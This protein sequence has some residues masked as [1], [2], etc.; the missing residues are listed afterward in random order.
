MNFLN[1]HPFIKSLVQLWA[2][3]TVGFNSVLL[4]MLALGITLSLIAAAFYAATSSGIAAT[5]DY[6]YGE[7]DSN[8]TFLSIKVTGTIVGDDDDTAGIAANEQYTSGYDVK[9][10]LYDAAKDD[11]ING[12][13]LEINSPGGTIYGAHAIADGVAHYKKE[14]H[15]PVVAYVQGMGTSGAYWAAVST[16]KIVADYGS[17]VGSIGVI[18]GPFEYYDT[19]VSDGNVVTQNGIQTVTI[20]A[21]TSK[22]V[23]NPYRKLTPAETAILQQSVNNDYSMFVK[24]V[25]ERRGIPEDTIRT[26][27]GAMPYDTTTALS[28]KLI[29][30]TGGK[31]DA[32]DLLAKQA[33][34]A[35]NDYQVIRDTYYTDGYINGSW[36]SDIKN[37]LTGKRAKTTSAPKTSVDSCALTRTNLAFYGDVTK[38]CN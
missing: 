34:V 24:Y 17:D 23:G 18:Q 29:D 8:N 22:D 36:V 1:R 16:D 9:Q 28:Y 20:T 38:F 19:P 15:K 30:Q 13:I 6:I 12:V 5:S 2:R 27:I 25:S 33:H 26:K 14:T 4:C 11:S 10:E 37:S 31:Q 32:Y 21:G 3:I 7:T 35:T